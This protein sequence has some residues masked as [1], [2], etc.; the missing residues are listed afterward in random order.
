VSTTTDG[1][2]GELHSIAA[3]FVEGGVLPSL[4]L[5]VAHRGRVIASRTYAKTRDVGDHTLYTIFSCTKAITASAAWLLEQDGKLDVGE[6]VADVI[7]E[8][9][10]HGKDV[11]TVEQLLTHTCGFPGA[12]FAPLDWNDRAKRL[13]RFAKWRLDW[14]PGSRFVYHPMT[15]FWVL[16][17]V[18]ERRAGQDFR[19]FVRERIVGPL[20]IADLFLGATEGVDAR[21]ADVVHV[22]ERPAAEALAGLGLSLP[23]SVTDDEKYFEAYNQPA[24]RAVGAPASGGVAAASALALFYQGLLHDL[25]AKDGEHRVW[26]P[27]TIARA[28]E[29]RTG[30]LIDPMTRRRAQRGLGV[31]VAG[32]DDRVFRGF[33]AA[34]SPL[35]FGHP[36]AGGQVAWADPATGLSFVCLTNGFDRDVI[37]LG[38]RGVVLSTLAAQCGPA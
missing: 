32:D 23:A 13:A 8:F 33:G 4:Q 1:P 29:L 36:G 30:D 19:A 5:A 15:S 38:M 10:T 14:E 37:R 2:L 16:A 9:G 28:L 27:A 7:P 6:R 34:T 18:I 21:V 12:P 31:V 35:A 20:G 17:E 26:R 25:A 22:G 24:I 3:S 11:V